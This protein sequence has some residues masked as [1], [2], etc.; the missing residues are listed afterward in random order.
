MMKPSVLFFAVLTA[1]QLAA[2]DPEW[3]SELTTVSPGSHP[4]IEPSSL[5]LQLS[6]KGVVNSG[7]LHLDFAPKDVKKPDVYVVRSTAASLGPAS[8]I[9]P[10]QSDFWSELD[11]SSLKA[12]LFHAVETDS[13]ETTT[14]T[15]R[16]FADRVEC[17]E[18]AKSTSTGAETRKSRVFNFAPV[19]DIFSAMLFVRSQKLDE[20]DKIAL[21]VNPFGTPYLLRVKV[22]ARENHLDRKA[23]RLTVGMRKIDA[24]TLELKPYKKLKSDATLWLSDDNDRIPIEFRAAVFIGDIRATLA[25]YQKS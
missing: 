19:F 4:P 16:H 21:V 17:D 15:T 24:K 12:R 9:F 18:V 6:W 14:T 20:G 10:Y 3:K 8:V 5:D 7:K 22:E 1:C 11:P 25:N 23:I 13:K 2:A